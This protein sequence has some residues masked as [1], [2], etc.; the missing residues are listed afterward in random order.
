L[1]LGLWEHFWP[2]HWLESTSTG[3]VVV[4]VAG[5]R[6]ISVSYNELTNITTVRL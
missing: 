1:S 6:M 3:S 2:E 4:T 5:R